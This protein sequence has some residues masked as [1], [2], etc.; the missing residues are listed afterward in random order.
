[1][2]V[3]P[4]AIYKIAARTGNVSQIALQGGLSTTIS[5]IGVFY[6]DK[7]PTQR[8]GIVPDIEV[9]PTIAG[10]RAGR[11]EVL[12]EAVRQLLR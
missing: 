2:P 12:D 1:L 3:S 8:V 6:P 4:P 5:G 10:I 7:K 11:D 9:K